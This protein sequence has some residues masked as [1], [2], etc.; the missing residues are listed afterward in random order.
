MPIAGH[1]RTPK[2]VSSSDRVAWASY[3]LERAVDRLAVARQ[4]HEPE[5][6]FIA[7]I[8]GRYTELQDQR[9][10]AA[11]APAAL[12]S[13]VPTVTAEASSGTSPVTPLVRHAAFTRRRG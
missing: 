10:L 4:L 1:T 3:A 7:A 8:L 11:T 9:H 2:P 12:A 6:A 5:G 13:K